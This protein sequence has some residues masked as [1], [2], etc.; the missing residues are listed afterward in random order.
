MAVNPA[1]VQQLPGREYRPRTPVERAFGVVASGLEGY[2][3]AQQRRAEI[4]SGEMRS[5]FSALIQEGL[6]TPSQYGGP[7]STKIGG[8]WFT[9]ATSAG[10]GVPGWK[11]KK[12]E[13]ELE[14]GRLDITGKKQT[15]GEL[16]KPKSR[17]RQDALKVA[18]NTWA[19]QDALFSDPDN[20]ETVLYEQ[21]SI[22][23]NTLQKLEEDEEKR[24]KRSPEEIILF[25]RIKKDPRYAGRTDDE[26]WVVVDYTKK[27][28][29]EG[30]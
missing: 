4:E 16:P 14:K 24:K 2:Q 26:I 21:A 28:S 29:K 17:Q 13:Q 25:E 3:K 27:Q 30:K 1:T 10:G 22:I 19:Y 6:V 9:P 7:D 12:R 8:M 11:Q 20:A 18:A 23:M 5:I 15:V